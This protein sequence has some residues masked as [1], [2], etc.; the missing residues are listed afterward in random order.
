[1]IDQALNGHCF[2]R[3]KNKIIML[4]GAT[5]IVITL[6]HL[7]FLFLGVGGGTNF[8]HLVMEKNPMQLIQRSFVE[9][10]KSV[11]KFAKFI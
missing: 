8:H 3:N 5:H 4:E 1:L 11:P 7:I 6:Q 9:K 2:D 10:K